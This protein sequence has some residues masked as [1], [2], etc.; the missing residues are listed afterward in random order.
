[1]P[2]SPFFYFNRLLIFKNNLMQRD[3]FPPEL[4][5]LVEPSALPQKTPK[6]ALPFT[7]PFSFHLRIPPLPSFPQQKILLIP[8]AFLTCSYP[9]PPPPRAFLEFG[10]APFPSG[11]GERGR[12]GRVRGSPYFRC[13]DKGGCNR[14][15]ATGIG[16]VGV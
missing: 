14:T 2:D 16:W 6:K 11:M 13:R 10:P 12:E 7:T 3:F 9:N 8:H 5:E 15:A 1:M 4:V